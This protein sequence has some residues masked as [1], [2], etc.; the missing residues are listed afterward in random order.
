[1][2]IGAG[3]AGGERDDGDYD[4]GDHGDGNNDHG[5]ERALRQP[6]LLRERLGRSGQAGG[7][8]RP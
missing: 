4:E 1:L 2:A 3:A 7:G 6:A 8:D 5:Y